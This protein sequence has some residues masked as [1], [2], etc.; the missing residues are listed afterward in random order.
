MR[1]SLYVDEAAIFVSPF[2]E[3]VHQFTSLSEGFGQVSSLVTNLEN[4]LVAPV[5][6]DGLNRDDILECFPATRAAFPLRY[7][8][9]PL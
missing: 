5:R 1:T 6:C 9:L 2:K 4:S 3:D 8:G 7:L